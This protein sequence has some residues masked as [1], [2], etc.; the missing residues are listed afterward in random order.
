MNNDD[1]VSSDVNNNRLRDV[2]TRTFWRPR[3]QESDIGAPRQNFWVGQTSS[4]RVHD[5]QATYSLFFL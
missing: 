2:R 5:L 3:P 4:P 1:V